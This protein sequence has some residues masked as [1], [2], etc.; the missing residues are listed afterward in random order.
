M[1]FGLRPDN[2]GWSR[3]E[4]LNSLTPVEPLL[5][6]EAR[7]QSWVAHGPHSS[8]WGL[9][10][11]RLH[12]RIVPVSQSPRFP[13]LCRPLLLTPLSAP[14]GPRPE[15]PHECRCDL[16][17]AAVRLW[18]ALRTGFSQAHP[19][20]CGRCPGTQRLSCGWWGR[21]RAPRVLASSSPSGVKGAKR[22]RKQESHTT[23]P[24]TG[25]SQGEPLLR[26]AVGRAV[27]SQNERQTHGRQTPADIAPRPPPPMKATL[28]DWCL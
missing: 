7:S 24:S 21:L 8:C 12:R 26:D 2:P 4:T 23:H 20:S 14:P 1:G 5:P 3:L 6:V 19:R 27:L 11:P 28:T 15:R 22:K 9:G 10:A 25:S 17:P 16:T 13:G 18:G